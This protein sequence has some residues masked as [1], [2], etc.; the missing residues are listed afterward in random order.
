MQN[1]NDRGNP[2]RKF[3]KQNYL[4]FSF[5]T[6]TSI[7]TR[8]QVYKDDDVVYEWLDEDE[9]EDEDEV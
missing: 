3:S 2:K 6:Q 8:I 4:I 9:D 1:K 5:P 7:Q